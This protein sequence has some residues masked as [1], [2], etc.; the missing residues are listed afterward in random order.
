MGTVF[1]VRVDDDVDP[2]TLAEVFDWLADVEDRFSTFKPAS[3]ISRIGRG[4][5]SVE[6]ADPDVRHVLAMCEEFESATEGRFSIR[7][8]RDGG[9]GIDPAGYVK[10]W[11]VDEAGLLLRLAGAE[12]FIIYAGGDVLCS[13]APADDSAWRVGVRLPS[14]PDSVGAIV[15]LNRGAVASSGAYERGN[16][17][18]GP[19]VDEGEVIG[20]SVVGPSLG[21]ADALAT[22]FYADQAQNLGWMNGY[23]DYGVLVFDAEGGV[24]WSASIDGRVEIPGKSAPK[25]G[26]NRV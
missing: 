21:H 19:G 15:S 2:E 6:S 12:N 13:G 25:A 4:E 8:G 7:P 18:W 3:Q 11:S 16:H 23:P 14:S 24:R 26:P 1:T 17:V 22:A 9:P 20:V 10:G 5:L